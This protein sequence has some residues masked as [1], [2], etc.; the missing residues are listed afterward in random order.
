MLYN[1]RNRFSIFISWLQQRHCQGEEERGASIAPAKFFPF[2]LK[3]RIAYSLK[4]CWNNNFRVSRDDAKILNFFVALLQDPVQELLQRCTIL[5]LFAPLLRS[6]D[7]ALRLA[8]SFRSVKTLA[9]LR[10]ASARFCYLT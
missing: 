9:S 4:A 5:R 3:I 10:F 2:I 8:F 7:A 6:I 1:I